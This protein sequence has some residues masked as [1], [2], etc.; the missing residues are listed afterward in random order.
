MFLLCRDVRVPQREKAGQTKIEDL[1]E[2][3]VRLDWTVR[4]INELQSPSVRRSFFKVGK[5]ASNHAR[6]LCLIFQS[7]S[8]FPPPPFLSI[9]KTFGDKIQKSKNRK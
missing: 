6:H 7:L 3:T 9:G 1:I 8:F 4:M 5:Q 2:K